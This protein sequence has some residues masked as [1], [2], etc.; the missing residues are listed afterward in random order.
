MR[1]PDIPSLA[2]QPA[3]L[4]RLAVREDDGNSMLGRE[5]DHLLALAAEDHIGGMHNS[6]CALLCQLRKGSPQVGH[7]VDLT[8]QQRPAAGICERLHFAQTGSGVGILRVDQK[9]NGAVL[10]N[11]FRPPF[12]SLCQKVPAEGAHA[13]NFPP[14]RLKLCTRPNSSGSL[15]SSNTIGMADVAAFAA[16]TERTAPPAKINATRRS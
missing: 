3:D 6:P 10:W 8:N 16:S 15:P 11:E 12:G 7:G 1:L 4:D 14:G 2:H 13:G 9:A 5:R